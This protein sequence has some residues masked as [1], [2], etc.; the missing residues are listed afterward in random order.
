MDSL[1]YAVD[2][3]DLYEELARAE[4]STEFNFSNYL[5]DN[6]L[7]NTKN[8]MVTVKFKEELEGVVMEEFCVLKHKMYSKQTKGLCNK[9]QFWN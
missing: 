5:S 1:T 8:Q 6:A 2:C 9:F 3:D 7:Y 4:V